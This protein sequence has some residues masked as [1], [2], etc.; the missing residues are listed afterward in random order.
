MTNINNTFA[1]EPTWIQRRVHK[2]MEQGTQE[3]LDWRKKGVGATE[4]SA[5]VGASL[6]DTA[7]SIFVKKTQPQESYEPT[8]VQEWGNRIEPLL[9][10][11]VLE[12]NNDTL[13]PDCIN[14]P[15]YAHE[16]RFCSLDGLAFSRFDYSKPGDSSQ[17]PVSKGVVP[18]IIEC[19]TSK[20][21][22]GW[23]DDSE[24]G[25]PDGYYAQVQWQMWVTGI[26]RAIF[27]V[28]VRG[29]EWFQVTVDYNH[30]Y[31]LDME[32]QVLDF[33]ECIKTNTPPEP[34]KKL[35]K[36]ELKSLADV[37]VINPDATPISVDDELVQ[38]FY[39]LKVALKE[40]EDALDNHKTKLAGMMV[41]GAPLLHGNKK[42]AS[43]VV[44]R[45]SLTVDIKKLKELYPKVYNNVTKLGAGSKYIRFS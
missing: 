17:H 1:D 30:E 8:A 11:K 2:D 36:V 3:W 13:Y 6:W 42:F 37:T 38:E 35:P 21:M 20:S 10:D 14:G 4:A 39:R 41:G 19:K 44:R 28:L 45:G 15:L 25:V 32:R 34:S 31:C 7:L 40:A 18:V 43:Y 24:H 23:G 5:I 9:I 16:H 27:S 33:W 22:D 26:K 29:S 12:E